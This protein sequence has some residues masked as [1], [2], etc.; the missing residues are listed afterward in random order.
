ME[1]PAPNTPSG[2]VPPLG[3]L[4]SEGRPG[5]PLDCISVHLQAPLPRSWGHGHQRAELCASRARGPGLLGESHG[6]LPPSATQTQKEGEGEPGC[7]LSPRCA[8]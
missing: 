1:D 5:V 4:R 6:V 3:R 8:T 2:A 7:P